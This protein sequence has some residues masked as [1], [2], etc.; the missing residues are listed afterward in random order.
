MEAEKVSDIRVPLVF[1]IFCLCL[2]T[3][4]VFLVFY[5]FVPK[6]SQPW[7]PI[8][9]LVLIGSPW[10]FWFFTYFYTCVKGCFGRGGGPPITADHQISRRQTTRNTSSRE[11]EMPLAY[12]A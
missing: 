10:I 4:G 9:A 7:Y 6:L 8:V 3:G 5:V 1:S 11:P 2:V 12:S